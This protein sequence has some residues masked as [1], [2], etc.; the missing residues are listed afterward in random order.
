[1]NSENTVSVKV[2]I[3]KQVYEKLK[4]D[5]QKYIEHCNKNLNHLKIDKVID[6]S[7]GGDHDDPCDPVKIPVFPEQSDNRNE[8]IQKC[9]QIDQV[10]TKV[11]IPEEKNIDIG[12]LS[13]DKILNTIWSRFKPKAKK[14]LAEFKKH[15]CN[16][17]WSSTGSIILNGESYPE[18][19]I[20][21]LLGVC[22]YPLKTKKLYCLPIFIEILKDLNLII[23]VKN[24]EIKKQTFNDVWYFI[25][26]IK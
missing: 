4:S 5:S 2:L 7:G 10:V 3:D 14:L 17:N 1:M 24:W 16:I 13:D 26:D 25:G 9:T 19:T 12:S 22:F 21:E 6:Q 15:P 18:A 11:D 20:S 8:T 23:F